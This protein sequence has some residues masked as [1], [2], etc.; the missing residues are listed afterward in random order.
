MSDKASRFNAGKVDLTLLPTAACR[1][2]AR[3][4]MAGARKYSKDNWKKLGMGDEAG[5]NNSEREL[6]RRDCVAH[7]RWKDL[8]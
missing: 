1:A 3:V 6:W 8:S 2:E 7:E 5:E 4:W